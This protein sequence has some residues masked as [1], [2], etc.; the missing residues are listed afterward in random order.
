MSLATSYDE[1]PYPRLAFPLTHPS[2]LATIGRLL[3]MACANVNSCRVLELGC[4]SGANLV[5][6]AYGL[7]NSRFVGVDFSERQISDGRQFTA[8]LGLENISL[9]KL[10]I[11]QVA[12]SLR[13][14]DFASRRDAAT[15]D[16]RVGA[17]AAERLGD[18]GPFN[19]IIAHGIYSW[20][21]DPVKDALLAACRRLLAPQGIAY[22]S[23]NCYPGCKTRDM[24]RQMC[25]YH[26]RIATGP[27]DYAAVTRRFL[28][29][30]QKALGGRSG[31]YHAV[32]RQ[33][34][35][36][37]AEVADEVLLHDDLERDNDPRFFHEFTSH[38]ASHRLAYLGDAYF[39]Q[40]FGAGIK[41]EALEKIR[42]A[43]DRCDF[44]QYLDFLYGRSLRTT[45][46]C[47]EEDSVSGEIAPD[48]IRQ[49]WIST[50]ARPT[51]ADG[52]ELPLPEIRFEEPSPVVFRAPEC[53]LSVGTL[54]GKA[55]L[56]ELA[57]AAPRMIDFNTLA[58]R[59][60]RR[61]RTLTPVTEPLP[62]SSELAKR[63]AEMLVEWFAMRLIEASAC[64]PPLTGEVAERPVASAV[65]RYQASRGWSQV[66]NLLHRRIRLDGELA[67][68][69]IAMLDG[70]NSRTDIVEALVKPV[71]EGKVAARIDGRQ[72]TRPD[73]IRPILFERV[74]ACLRDFA[75]HAL[76][77]DM[78]QSPVESSQTWQRSIE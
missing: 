20:V 5:P 12:E 17:E 72:V 52:K 4:A 62:S 74:G 63:L 26:G 32:L 36:D 66:T 44:E 61:L 71:A 37:L 22:V 60:E 48:G 39:G 78:T 33:H 53:T 8:A 70:R 40:M 27:R 19:Y 7:P 54:L 29:F 68:R 15:W 49:L 77:V 1:V 34:V 6:M 45:L 57:A 11:R 56:V 55:T 69:V 23:Y 35:G 67:C 31:A 41:P 16:S 50:E 59:V 10:D 43:G 75:K 30:L 28:E 51:S 46:L 14:S 47:R 38:A 58:G 18:A 9:E 65:A 13:D 3:G 73:Q 21:P 64:A 25:Q 24:L 42:H 2:H 76:L